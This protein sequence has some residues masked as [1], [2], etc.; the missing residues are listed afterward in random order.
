MTKEQ[1]RQSNRDK[2]K[3][4]AHKYLDYRAS[5]QLKKNSE[6]RKQRVKNQ[7]QDMKVL[8]EEI[9]KLANSIIRQNKE[10]KYE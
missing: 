5:W 3:R 10:V 8:G 1:I 9:I 7:A 2:Q 4:N 6:I